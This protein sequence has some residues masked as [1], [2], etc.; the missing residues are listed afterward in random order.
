MD[1]R[2][3]NSESIDLTTLQR[4]W[5]QSLE[6]N[7]RYYSAMTKLMA[8]YYK[9]LL[10]TYAGMVSTQGQTQPQAQA[11]SRPASAGRPSSVPRPPD[12]SPVTTTPGQAGVMVLENESGGEALGI[13][14]VS[15]NLAET[16]SARVTPSE[17]VNEKGHIVQLTFTFD[18]E[19]ISLAPGEQLLVRVTTRIPEALEPQARYRGEFA[20]PELSGTRIPIV[21]RRRPN[22]DK[23][24]SSD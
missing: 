5:G 18:P 4:L 2:M 20:V 1:K 21:V 9:D 6:L 17:F 8:D 14:L 13:F 16:V 19:I 24:E 7:I 15:N 23:P 3:P 22:I 12:A 11:T 10:A